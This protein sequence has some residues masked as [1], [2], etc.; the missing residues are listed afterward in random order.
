MFSIAV[1]HRGAM[2][3][4][5][6]REKIGDEEFFTILQTWTATTATPTPRPRS[7]SPW[8]SRSPARTST[9]FFHDVA[10]H[11]VQA[12]ELVSELR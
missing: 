12:E 10:L 2:T 11:A 3:L 4:Q 5:A 8:P 6:L 7:S 9:P 1:Y